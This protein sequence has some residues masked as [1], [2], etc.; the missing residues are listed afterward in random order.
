M[1]DIPDT[2]EQA[3]PAAWIKL[4]Q[5]ILFW[6]VFMAII[7]YALF[8]YLRQNRELVAKL[9]KVRGLRW[10][11]EAFRWL[12]GRLRGF[13][14]AAARALAQ[15]VQRLRALLGFQER[16]AF[17]YISLRRM[18]AR[19]KVLFYYLA[20][21]RRGGETGIK[22]SQAQTPY[23]YSRS[24]MNSVSDMEEPVE[25]MTEAFVEARYSKHAVEEAKAGTVKQA[26][27]R[28]RQA[29]RQMGKPRS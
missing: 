15:G 18:S 6:A 11:G 20:L 29:L 9:R 17:S 1:P 24:L 28:V 2:V 8:Q 12:R 19:Q 3:G 25:E 16:E 13:N 10:L 21:V 14:Q 27:E 23:E 22:R 7:G 4:V 5:S 26:W